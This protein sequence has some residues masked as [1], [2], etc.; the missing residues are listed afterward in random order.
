MN[1]IP[2]VPEALL[3]FIRRFG[4]FLLVGHK[5]PDG[6]CIGSQ[7][8]LAGLLERQGKTVRNLNPGPFERQEISRYQHRFGAGVDRAGVDGTVLGGVAAAG[9]PPEAAVVVDC[10]SADRIVPLDKALTG[11]PVAVIDHHAAGERFGDVHYIEPRIP[12]TTI[13]VFNLFQTLGITPTAEESQ[14]LFLGL[15]TDTGFFRFLSP[16]QHTAFSV[17]AELTRTG[18][19]PREVDR[20]ISTGRPLES[21]FLLARILHRVEALRD[22]AFLLT[23]QTLADEKEFGTRRDSDALYRLLLAVDGVRVVALVKEKD[24]GCAVSFRA[25]DDTDVGALAA[26]FGGGGHQKASG[27]FQE[28]DLRE[29]LPRIRDALLTLPF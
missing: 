13:L 21:R 20:L 12:A 28:S 4:S 3:D 25:I 19:S 26:R 5:E 27:A 15:A 6:D 8:A 11:L 10:S 16:E 18:A 14:A 2:P 24:R 22:G 23:Y 1:E 29:F 9:P 7:I 17:A